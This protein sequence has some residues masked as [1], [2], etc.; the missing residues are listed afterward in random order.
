M[1]IDGSQGGEFTK[2]SRSAS[3]GGAVPLMFRTPVW[4]RLTGAGGFLLA[5]VA[6]FAAAIAVEDPVR[7][8]S[9][10]IGL[11]LVFVAWRFWRLRIEADDESILVVDWLRKTRIPWGAIQRFSWDPFLEVLMRDGT[12]L[13]PAAFGTWVMPLQG[14]LDDLVRATGRRLQ[15]ELR[16]QRHGK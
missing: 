8:L 4:H 2:H 10:A 6:A 13:R 1:E 16:R 9:T 5:S 12:S 11:G 7:L 3:H 15:D 14:Q